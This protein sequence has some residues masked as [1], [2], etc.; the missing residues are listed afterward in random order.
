MPE[1]GFTTRFAP[2]PTGFLHLGHVASALMVWGVARAFGG[3]V[4]LRVE[5]HD[6]TRYRPEFEG[7]ILED[8][9]WLGFTPDEPFTRQSDRS[10]LYAATLEELSGRGLIY[11]CDCSRKALYPSEPSTN[12]E[13]RYPGTCRDRAVNSERAAG[14]RIR[15][16]PMSVT[17]DDLRLG[18]LTQNPAEETGDV[19]V[20][21]RNGHWT[22]QFAVVVDDFDQEVDLVIRGED[23]LP[24]T[25]RQIQIA[26]LI[27]RQ[28][29]PRFLHH[30]LIRN[31]SGQ[32]LSKSNR[33]TGIRELRAAG[34]T[35]EHVLGEAA[36]AAGLASGAPI[37]LDQF[38]R[39]LSRS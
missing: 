1:R 9:E 24:S 19:L 22:Y 34:W 26:R 3:R 11:T 2:A 17:F 33:D 30:A 7:A 4:L 18:A 32:K 12:G 29:P 16:E 31:P 37:N 8:L 28:T 27:G 10:P 15:L 5:D 38:A 20:R 23:L 21:D 13:R 6:R 36:G 14:R 25:G 39:G 35:A